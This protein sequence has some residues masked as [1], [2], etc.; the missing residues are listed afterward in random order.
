M[1]AVAAE[2]KTPEQPV[3]ATLASPSRRAGIPA[4]SMT[5]AALFAALL[6]ASSIVRIPI[7][8]SEVPL[9]LQVLIVLLATLLLT[10]AQAALAVGVYIAAGAIGLPVFAGGTAGLGVLA[11]P[12]G[13]Y[14]WGFLAG[15]V[16]GSVAREALGRVNDLPIVSDTVAVTVALVVIYALGAAQLALVA[17]LPAGVAIVKGVLPY[18]PFDVL[19]AAAAVAVASAVRRAL[20]GRIVAGGS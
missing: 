12:T 19:K 9:T 11:G 16:A 6:A 14:L 3:R 7:P 8:A 2:E 1:R 15:A 4:R 10:P 5:T 13:G 20:P 17:H 18:A